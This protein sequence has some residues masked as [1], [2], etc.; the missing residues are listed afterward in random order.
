MDSLES[1]VL[2]LERQNRL[3][4]GCLAGLA[5]LALAGFRQNQVPDLAQA[6]RIQVVDDHDVP[7]VTL[8]AG[9]DGGGEVVLR[10]QSGDRR[11]WINTGNNSARLGMVSGPEET[12]MS[13]LGLAVESGR[14]RMTITGGRAGASLGVE[15]EQPSIDLTA[16]D[17]KVVFAAPWRKG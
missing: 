5:L 1:R 8:D 14:S 13:S 9:R 2:R 4:L 6:K 16:K 12:P 3:L 15:N 10:D 7:L 11:A 17:G